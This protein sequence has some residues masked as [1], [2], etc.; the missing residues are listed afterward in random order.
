M[1]T[2]YVELMQTRPIF[3]K[4]VEQMGLPITGEELACIIS[5]SAPAENKIL[6]VSVVDTNPARAAQIANTFSEVFIEENEKRQS[7]RYADSITARQTTLTGL[8]DQ[9]ELVNTDIN[10]LDNAV[11]PEKQAQLSRLQTQLRELQ[12]S[13]TQSFNDL[14]ELKIEQARDTN[15]ILIVEPA[16]AP[17]KRI[18]PNPA[19]NTLLAAIVGA[20]MAVGVIFLIDYLDDTVKTP[21]DIL[22]DTGLTSSGGDR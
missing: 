12:I 19:R 11:S 18:S 13:Y 22:N 7:Q 5:V 10:A 21:E 17:S 4:T 6:T 8:A 2:T 1:A 20:M 9:I 14:E 3:D 16:I 15:N